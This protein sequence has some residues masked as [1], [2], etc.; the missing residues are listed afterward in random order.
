M[1]DM[2]AIGGAER[3]AALLSNYFESNNCKVHH[4]I[5]QDFVEYDYSG[6]LLNLGQLKDEAKFDFFNR[7]KRFLVLYKF[8]R[9]NKFDFIID[10]RVRSGQIQE[11]VIA[12]FIYNAPLIVSIRSFMIDLYF[13]KNKILANSIYSKAKK[14][15][16]VS[17]EIQNKIS[18]EYTYTQ[19]QTIYNPI[20]F[21]AIEK[22][23][24]EPLKIDFDYVLAVGRM[25]DEVKQ[26]DRLIET[27]ASSELPSKNIKLVLLGDGIQK[28]KYQELAKE[29]KLEEMIHFEGKVSNPFNYM[30]QA[31]LLLLTSKNEGFPNVILESLA[32]ETPVVAFDCHSGPSEIIKSNENGI[33]VE[34][35]NFEA[36]KL[37][38]NEMI[39]NNQLYL[40]CKEN[41]K[42]SVERF[43]LENIGKQWM[44]LFKELS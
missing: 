11:F 24:D 1:S 2:L 22:L 44:Q 40:H 39:S 10:F 42:T 27:Y 8:F 18:K 16:T 25:A 20:D 29:L 37:A 3:C 23:A 13:P 15:I 14:I 28:E 35:Q 9:K 31:K 7:F 26:F 5:V 6:E 34:N 12:K 36:F 17:Q 32:C 33:L 41:A 4:V 21:K 43:S 30:K 19:L 38:L